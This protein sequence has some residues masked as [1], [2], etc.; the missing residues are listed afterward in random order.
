MAG[1]ADE[2]AVCVGDGGRAE[3]LGGVGAFVSMGSTNAPSAGSGVARAPSTLPAGCRETTPTSARAATDTNK[4]PSASG[5]L[6]AVGLV[7]AGRSRAL[8]FLVPG[9]ALGT[10]AGRPQ[11]GQAPAAT[12]QHFAQA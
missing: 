6:P 8:R 5:P 10:G 9:V 7:A 4:P 12:V 2:R 3:P 1:V 11:P